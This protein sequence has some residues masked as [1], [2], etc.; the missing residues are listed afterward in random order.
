MS[1]YTVVERGIDSY[2]LHTDLGSVR[3]ETPLH[4]KRIAAVHRGAGPRDIKELKWRSLDGYLQWLASDKGAHLI[5]DRVDHFDWKDGRPQI[6]TR[7]GL[8]QEYDLLAVAARGEH[9]LPLIFFD[10]GF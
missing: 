5:C 8:V 10:F 6:K 4:E 2:V 1:Y 9:G 3:I 7:G